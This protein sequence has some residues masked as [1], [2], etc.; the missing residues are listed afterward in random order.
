MSRHRFVSK[1]ETGG[2]LS[3]RV[4]P[5]SQERESYTNQP[6]TAS[7][8]KEEITSAASVMQEERGLEMA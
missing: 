6:L 8:R 4:L 2:G 1:T 3:A 5:V 7:Y